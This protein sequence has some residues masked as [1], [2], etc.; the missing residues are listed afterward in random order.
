MN[1]QVENMPGDWNFHPELPLENPSIFQ[2]PIRPAFLLK[3][4]AGNWLMLSE[5]VM[6]LL[7]A[8]LLWYF[9]YPSLETAKYLD[10]P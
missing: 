1:K 10:V 5:R 7:V 6:M 4:L 2:W 8:V 3:W 9:C